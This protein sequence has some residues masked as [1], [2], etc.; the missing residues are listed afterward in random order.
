ME[1]HFPQLYDPNR[2]EKGTYYVAVNNDDHILGCIGLDPDSED[3]ETLWLRCLC[4][5]KDLR[6]KGIAKHLLTQA[7]ETARRMRGIVRVR[8]TTVDKHSEYRA[9]MVAGNKIFKDF[10][11]K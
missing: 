5:A 7:L 3:P 1:H 2:F 10:G 8:L 11:F 4:V 9:L 6:N